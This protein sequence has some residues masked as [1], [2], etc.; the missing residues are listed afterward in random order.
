MVLNV[1]ETV[2]GGTLVGWEVSGVVEWSAGAGLGVCG[3]GGGELREMLGSLATARFVA[4]LL[5]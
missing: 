2:M 1:R 3:R 5:S 4:I